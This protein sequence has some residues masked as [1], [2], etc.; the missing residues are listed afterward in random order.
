MGRCANSHEEIYILMEF[1]EKE[2][3]QTAERETIPP[4][5]FPANARNI[6]N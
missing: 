3:S 6:K 5:I 2:A 4:S 1:R